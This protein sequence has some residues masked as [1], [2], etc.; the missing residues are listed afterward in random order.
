MRLKKK[1]IKKV[2]LATTCVM[3]LLSPVVQADSM[4]LKFAHQNNVYDAD[5]LLAETFKTLLEE[6]TGGDLKISIYPGTLTGSEEEALEFAKAGTVALAATSAGHI[7]GY[8]EDIQFLQL[9]YLFKSL[10]HYKVARSSSVVKEILAGAS[11]ATG[12]KALGVYSDCNGFAIASKEP[13]NSLSD[14]KGVKLRAMQ[15]PLFIDIYEAFGFT[16]TPTDWGEL[17]TSLQTGMVEADDL[18]VYCNDIFKMSEVVDSYAILNQMWTQKI[19][20]MSPKVWDKLTDEQKVIVTDIADEAIELTD[21]WQYA[22]E[23]KFIE[24]VK[25]D[26]EQTITYPDTD[27]FKTASESVYTKWF[28]KEPQWKKWY[29]EIQYLDPN[30]RLPKAFK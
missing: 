22:R 12:M 8:Y 4:R 13:I 16:V 11:K 29:E 10:E 15:N 30:A 6:K 9:P 28:A 17:Y 23:A 14:A 20:F 1:V 7:A 5:Q 27:E 26:K 21:A 25:K 19:L 24:Q 18:G 3:L 2:T